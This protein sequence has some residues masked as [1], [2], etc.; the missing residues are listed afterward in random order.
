MSAP[1]SVRRIDLCEWFGRFPGRSLLAVEAHALRSVWPSL[2]GKTVVQLGSLGDLDLLD[3]CNAPVR[4]LLDLPG[5]PGPDMPRVHSLPEE[6]P[7]DQR[8]VDIVLLPHTLEFAADPH[9]VLREVSRVLSPEGHVVILGFNP[10]SLWG[11]R[12]L[13]ARRQRPTPW[14][15]NFLHLNRLKDWLKLLNFDLVQGGMLYYRPPLSS[16]AAM[17]RLRFLDQAGNRWWPMAG[18]V[19]LL[20]AKKRVLGM[21][22][23]RPE[24]RSA[25]GFGK[26]VARPALRIIRGGG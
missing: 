10:F 11:L 5:S 4:A 2:F 22:A 1:D 9:Q 24:W 19:Y 7:F 15:G 26:A 23:L 18:A 21:T 17:D 8:S 20:V 14:N 3:D 25:P 12:R 6:L 13:L 16:E